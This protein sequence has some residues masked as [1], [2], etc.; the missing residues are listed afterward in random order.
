MVITFSGGFDREGLHESNGGIG[1]P[2][3]SNQHRNQDSKEVRR[4]GIDIRSHDLS[5][6]GQDKQED[7]NRWHQDGGAGILTRA[8]GSSPH[9]K[10]VVRVLRWFSS[11]N[12]SHRRSIRQG[13]KTMN[14]TPSF[15]LFPDTC[16]TGD[17][18]GCQVPLADL[19]NKRAYDLFERRGRGHSH[20]IEDWLRAE[21][22]I[23]HHLGL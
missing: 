22:E 13:H 10:R 4:P 15:L 7:Q 18:S 5:I 1:T 23:K 20:E 17:T 12:R 2:G 21:H 16:P 6:I 3:G 8:M 9:S 14:S 19:I 11:P